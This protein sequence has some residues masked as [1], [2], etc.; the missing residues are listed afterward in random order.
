LNQ[1]DTAL[2]KIRNYG[3]QYMNGSTKAFAAGIIGLFLL[4]LS[5]GCFLF[6]P[7]LLITVDIPAVEGVTVPDVDEEDPSTVVTETAQYTGTVSWSP[8]DDDFRY[9]TVYTATITLTPK[10]GYTLIGVPQD[11]FSVAGADTVTNNADSGV[12][13]AVFPETQ[14]PE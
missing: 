5:A 11:F 13:T 8:D 6:V 14:S 1:D 9:S 2:N 12:I 10:T 7:D 3:D 4:F